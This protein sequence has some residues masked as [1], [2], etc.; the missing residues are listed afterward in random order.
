MRCDYEQLRQTFAVV[1]RERDVTQQQKK[2]LQLRV[3][4]LEQRLKV[5]FPVKLLMQTKCQFC[6]IVGIQYLLILQFLVVWCRDD[7]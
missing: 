1:S 6:F 2:H 3:D 5:T 7:V 4:T